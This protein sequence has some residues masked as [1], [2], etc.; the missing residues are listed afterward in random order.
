MAKRHRIT[1][2]ER[3]LAEPGVCLGC[4][5]DCPNGR[6]TAGQCIDCHNAANRAY[7]AA[8]KAENERRAHEGREFWAS[9]GIKVGQAVRWWAPSTLGLGGIWHRGVAKTGATGAYVYVKGLGYKASPQGW[10]A[11]EEPAGEG[12]EQ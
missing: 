1:E 4:G 11:V 6:N 7:R 5:K 10:K 8:R 3:I 9:K 12:Q 2:A